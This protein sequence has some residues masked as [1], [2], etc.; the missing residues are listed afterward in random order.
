MSSRFITAFLGSAILAGSLS[1]V[2]IAQDSTAKVKPCLGELCPPASSGE[3]M[4]TQKT[5][6][7]PTK[8]EQ[9]K[10]ATKAE[11]VQG[12]DQP[13]GQV[14]PRKKKQASLRRNGQQQ[15]S[16]QATPR[17]KKQASAYR[18]RQQQPNKKAASRSSFWDWLF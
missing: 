13:A 1:G 10:S 18:D 9:M 6:K 8:A 7:S 5:M 4:P 3:D 17:K 15:S 11:Q 12:Q 14:T 2:A 16:N